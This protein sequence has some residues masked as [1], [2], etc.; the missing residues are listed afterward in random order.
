MTS[1]SSGAAALAVISLL[2]GIPLAAQSDVE[3]GRQLYRANCFVCHGPDG[4]SIAGVNLRSGQFRRASSDDDLSRLI[5]GGIPGTG[6]P[7]T[8]LAEPQR[9]MLVAYIR[10]MHRGVGERGSGDAARGL[11]IVE[12][13]GACLNCHRVGAKGSRLGPDL[14]D[15]GSTKPAAYLEEALVNPSET[16]APQNRF[17][18]A[19]TKQG[20]VI[21]GRR[22]N[23]DTHTIQLI[24][25]KQRL[26]SLQK[27]DL[28]EFEL[29]KTS[30]MPSY[31]DKLSAQELADTV[32]YLL[33]LKGAQ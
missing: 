25:E 10:S 21:D 32:S 18:H 27:A 13:K 6:M 3:A 11:A 24:D 5:L 2:G 17:V 23:E 19:V 26:V 33:S 22:L 7:P 30:P 1:R 16:I 8:N 29:V 4:E 31:R 28:R 15:I 20:T 12:G 9:R 14:T